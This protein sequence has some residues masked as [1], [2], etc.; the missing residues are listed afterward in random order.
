M[1][2]YSVT[3]RLIIIEKRLI[4]VVFRLPI[5]YDDQVLDADETVGTGERGMSGLVRAGSRPRHAT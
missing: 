2:N 4:M 3:M 5:R 1:F